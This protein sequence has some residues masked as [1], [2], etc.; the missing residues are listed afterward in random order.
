MVT[1][2]RN[3]RI[4]TVGADSIGFLTNRGLLRR[5]ARE[6]ILE[7]WGRKLER[8]RTPEVF[9]T[10]D[11]INMPQAA[12]PVDGEVRLDVNRF[13]IKD[14]AAMG[15]MSDMERERKLIGD[16]FMPPD[17]RALYQRE[18]S[19]GSETV[20]LATSS[21]H[22]HTQTAS[23]QG[24][25]LF[26]QIKTAS[27]DTMFNTITSTPGVPHLSGEFGCK[28]STSNFP[29]QASVLHPERSENQMTLPPQGLLAA[30]SLRSSG[31]AVS[32]EQTNSQSI[33]PASLSEEISKNFKP[34]EISSAVPSPW[35]H[36]TPSP[37][38]ELFSRLLKLVLM[39]FGFSNT[40]Y[41]GGRPEQGVR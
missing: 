34:A 35:H 9:D 15:G 16:V 5:L 38:V 19:G 20:G 26:L 13:Q 18:A 10:L 33:H 6:I 37:F 4:T 39:L 7:M 3:L 28:A 1:D 2:S 11:V 31:A 36:K 8:N 17:I 22:P 41:R 21:G 27:R 25:D 12:T 30:G 29:A 14:H 24:A 32:P 40:S 23:Q